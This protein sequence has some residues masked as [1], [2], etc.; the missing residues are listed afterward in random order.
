MTPEPPLGEEEPAEW[1][2]AED[3]SWLGIPMTP[4]QTR[5]LIAALRA[6]QAELERLREDARENYARAEQAEQALLRF[7]ASG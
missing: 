4:V 7:N 5:R 6:S 3:R 2:R 1:K